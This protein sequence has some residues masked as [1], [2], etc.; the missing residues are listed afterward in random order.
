MNKSKSAFKQKQKKDFN[1]SISEKLNQYKNNNEKRKKKEK[2]ASSQDFSDVKYYI[3][4]KKKHISTSCSIKSNSN[5][6]SVNQL[7]A[8]DVKNSSVLSPFTS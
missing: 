5:T 6:I 4:H 1:H 2:V 7:G 3:C 8:D